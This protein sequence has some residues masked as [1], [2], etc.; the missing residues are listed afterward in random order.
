VVL[1]RNL[2]ANLALIPAPFM[3]R[4]TVCTPTWTPRLARRLRI[5]GDPQR[6]LVSA[7]S[8]R[9]TVRSDS[10]RSARLEPGARRNRYKPLALT[11]SMR[12][13]SRTANSGTS[14][15]RIH[16]NFTTGPWQTAP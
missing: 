15:S 8:M 5:M 3:S 10:V 13:Q 2:R 7:C 6:C 9:I 14:A 11:S 16:A 4:A 1:G 12:Q